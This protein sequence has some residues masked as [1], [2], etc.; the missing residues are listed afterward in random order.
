MGSTVG[1]SVTGSGIILFRLLLL[2]PFFVV[3]TGIR[4][5]EKEAEWVKKTRGR[6]PWPR[7]AECRRGGPSFS[8]GGP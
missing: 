4:W 6:L 3:D 1:G 8:Q 2:P 5:T 7:T